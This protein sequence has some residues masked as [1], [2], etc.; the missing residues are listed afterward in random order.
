MIDPAVH[1]Q[2]ISS[3]E[4]FD[5][6]LALALEHERQKPAACDPKSRERTPHSHLGRKEGVERRPQ[7]NTGASHERG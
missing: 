7:S 4:E 5:R 6:W 3:E 1:S 2:T